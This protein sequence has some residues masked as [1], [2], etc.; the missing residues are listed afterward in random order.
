L[1]IRRLQINVSRLWF[2]LLKV[3]NIRSGITFFVRACIQANIIATILKYMLCS[4]TR[5]ESRQE[6]YWISSM[7]ARISQFA[8]LNPEYVASNSDSLNLGL[9]TTR[10]CKQ[11]KCGLHQLQFRENIKPQKMW[12]NH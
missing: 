10:N 4:H 9:L 11:R 5:N 1:G 7:L 2:M 8:M 12:Y 6:G 3:W